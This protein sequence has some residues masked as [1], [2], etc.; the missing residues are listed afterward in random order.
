MSRMRTGD[1]VHA[2]FSG[3]IFTVLF[4]TVGFL[5]AL[6]AGGLAADLRELNRRS[7]R[8]DALELRLEES[9]GATAAALVRLGATESDLPLLEDPAFIHAHLERI[10]AI[11]D[12][13]AASAPCI[14]EERPLTQGLSEYAARRSGRGAVGGFAAAVVEAMAPPAQARAL[15]LRG[16]AGPASERLEIEIRIIGASPRASSA[17]SVQA[18]GGQ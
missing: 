9:R 17:E 11:F 14:I 7:A 16:G 2:A 1:I 8:I 5:L 18:G 13:D 3:A 12:A 10:C 15:T 6:A 4:A